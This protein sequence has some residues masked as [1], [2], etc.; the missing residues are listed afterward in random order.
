MYR[1]LDIIISTT[2]WYDHIRT[3]DFDQAAL[4]V[5][6]HQYRNN[7]LY[8]SYC[9]LIHTVPEKVLDIRDIPFLPIH[10]F[11]THTV[12]TGSPRHF[13]AVFESSGTTQTVNSKH[14]IPSLPLYLDTC[15]KGFEARFGPAGSYVFLCLLPSYLERKNSS[16]VY[17]AQHLID[18]SRQPESGF[19]LYDLE[20]LS[21]TITTLKAA[22]RKII[23]L[24]VTFA[25]IDFAE[26]FPR[27]LQD[28]IIIE[29]GGMKGKKE[30]WTR[31]QVHDYLKQQ[32]QVPHI[33]SE[34]GMTE[35][36]S[37][38]YSTGGENFH[39]IATMK[40]LVRDEYDPLLTAPA[41]R[42]PLNIIDLSNIYSCSFIATEDIGIVH[43]DGTFEVLGRLDASA[44]RG[45]SLM[46][47]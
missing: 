22:N 12:V 15:L 30:E 29:T 41:G 10:F 37:Q 33:C 31:R 39:P 25:L 38:A 23:L 11:K 18:C 19:Y 20:R 17:M 24:G 3:Q 5:F 47:I 27:D 32:W 7:T 35:L 2:G 44:L 45:C 16:L 1:N 8:R 34:Y 13:D 28:V 4:A 21:Q 26:Q 36:S 43:D 42:G 14:Y 9:D 46:T 6:N 40:A